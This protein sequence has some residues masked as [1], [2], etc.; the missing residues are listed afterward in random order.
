MDPM[1]SGKC[2]GPVLRRSHFFVVVA[3]EGRIEATGTLGT[4][5]RIIHNI[6]VIFKIQ[7]G[8]AHPFGVAKAAERNG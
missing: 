1:S 7:D 5:T 2:R 8:A 4:I 3:G 6:C